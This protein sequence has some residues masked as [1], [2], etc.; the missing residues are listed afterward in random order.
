MLDGFDMHKDLMGIVPHEE[1]VCGECKKRMV[2]TAPKNY[3][4]P[5][6][7]AEFNDVTGGK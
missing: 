4:C 6:C 2:E 3:R 1:F 5:K 7:G